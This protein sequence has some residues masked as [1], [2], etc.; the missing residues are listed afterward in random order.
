MF[1]VMLLAAMLGVDGECWDLG[2]G[3]LENVGS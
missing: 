2:L 1:F 3:L